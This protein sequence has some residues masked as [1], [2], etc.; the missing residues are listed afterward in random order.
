LSTERNSRRWGWMK[1]TDESMSPA[2]MQHRA[3]QYRKI[4]LVIDDF[5]AQQTLLE[6]AAEYEAQVEA[7][8]ASEKSRYGEDGGGIG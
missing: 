1:G 5:L 2:E 8:E 6:L 3:A 7:A 4:A